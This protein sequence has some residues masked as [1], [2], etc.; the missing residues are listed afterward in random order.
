MKPVVI[1]IGTG[2]LTRESDG[3]LDR[4]ALT[5]LVTAVADL[6][7]SGQ[8]CVLVSSGAVGAGVSQLGLHEY[9][10]DVPTRQACAAV[11]QTRLMHAYENLFSNFDL[12][13]AQLLLTADDFRDSARLRRME[14]TL[15][16]LSQCAKI[17]PIINENDSVA[18]E[19]LSMGDNDM[20]SARVAGVIGASQLILLS[21]IDGL[22]AP[23]ST[24]VIPLVEKVEDVLGFIRADKGKFSI[25]GMA[26]KLKAVQ[27]AL[28]GGIETV[29]AHGKSP[30]RLEA[31]TRGEGLCTR[32][33][34][35]Q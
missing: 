23:E 11:G 27:V 22:L 33:L 17:V 13:V 4:A 28:D 7:H 26:S 19:E 10:S 20:L 18:V 1:K 6:V 9:P 5:K 29:I 30:E 12:S 14:D 15:S 32:F 25:G 35:P 2:V 8:P 31:I 16:R 21:N 34:V 3:L 24:E